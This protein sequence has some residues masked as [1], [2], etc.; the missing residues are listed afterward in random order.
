MKN[1]NT[2]THVTSKCS[3]CTVG[4][5]LNNG[6]CNRKCALRTI[7]KNKTKLNTLNMSL[8][9]S[10]NSDKFLNKILD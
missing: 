7:V 10:V 1:D 5:M 8:D 4:D 6:W 3:V 2:I 9:T